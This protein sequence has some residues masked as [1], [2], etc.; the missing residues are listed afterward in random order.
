M[1]FRSEGIQG[2]ELVECPERT[3]L[4]S[5]HPCGGSSHS[6]VNPPYKG[7][8]YQSAEQKADLEQIFG[9]VRNSGSLWIMLLDG[10]R[11]LVDYGQKTG[12]SSAFV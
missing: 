12:S 7:I 3:G 5:A 11:R 1:C 9:S 10:S 6:W 8:P 4:M 2:I